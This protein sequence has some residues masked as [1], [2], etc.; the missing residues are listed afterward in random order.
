MLLGPGQT[1][2]TTQPATTVNNGETTPKTPKQWETYIE[3]L[4]Y[5]SPEREAA[6]DE[7]W[8]QLQGQ[9]PTQA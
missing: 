6:W 7:Y 9:K 8:N 1:N 3:S 2:T 4:P 5:G